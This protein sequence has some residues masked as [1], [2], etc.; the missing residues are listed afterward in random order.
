MDSRKTGEFIRK[1]RTEL[2]LTQ[3]ELSEK[4]GCTD[5]AVSR[6]ETGKGAQMYLFSLS[7]HQY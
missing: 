5:K 2:N 1:K 7:F 6:W 3:K 4:L